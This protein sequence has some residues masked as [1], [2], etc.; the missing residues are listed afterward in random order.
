MSR[1]K[2]NAE[3]FRKLGKGKGQ[4]RGFDFSYLYYVIF[5]AAIVKIAFM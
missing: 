1:T 5:A 2:K 4:P 3:N